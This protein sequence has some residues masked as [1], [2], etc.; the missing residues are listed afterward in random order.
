MIN[1]QSIE[2]FMMAAKTLSFAEASRQ[3]YISRQA[4]NKQIIKLEEDLKGPL[5]KRLSRGLELTCAGKLYYDYFER[6]CKDFESVSSKVEVHRLRNSKNVTV[7]FPY[8]LDINE[9]VAEA[10][11]AFGREFPEVNINI[12]RSY[13]K[14]LEQMLVE[15]KVNL[16]IDF[17][18]F[19][20][21]ETR[22]YETLELVHMSGVL[23]IARNNPKAVDGA[24]LNDLVAN[25]TVIAP[26]DIF[27]ENQEISRQKENWDDI[28]YESL[29]CEVFR[30][31]DFEL[32]ETL[33]IMG[34]G[35]S[36]CTS[37]NKMCSN[38]KIRT[39]SF[40]KPLNLLCAWKRDDSNMFRL[41]RYIHDSMLKAPGIL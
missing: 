30:T 22:Q 20:I 13:P 32:A 38:P 31:N 41:A 34:K 16:I 8:A 28:D 37:L 19:S 29:G 21:P 33:T 3:L 24:Q 10:L 23:A 11:I 6:C 9:Q 12:T 14:V 7:G 35:V 26:R 4:L 25:E 5:F 1:R 18:S 2:Y 36:I 27:D 15:G 17:G 40:G 39:Y